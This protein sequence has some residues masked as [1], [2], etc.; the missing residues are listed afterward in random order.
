MSELAYSLMALVGVGGMIAGIAG[1]RIP[2]MSKGT[3]TTL[4]LVGALF[5]AFGVLG[6]ASLL[7]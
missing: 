3:S 7:D 6:V 2:S 1:P 5:T 4:I